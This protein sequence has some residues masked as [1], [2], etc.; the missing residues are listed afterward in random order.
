MKLFRKFLSLPLMRQLYVGVIAITIFSIAL[1]GCLVGLFFWNSFIIQV[2]DSQNLRIHTTSQDVDNWMNELMDNLRFYS[3]LFNN[4]NL[5]YGEQVLMGKALL[6]NNGAIHSITMFA[7]QNTTTFELYQFKTDEQRIPIDTEAYNLAKNR[8][9]EF[10]GKVF[11][12]DGQPM[13]AISLPAINESN[14]TVGVIRAIVNLRYMQHLFAVISHEKFGYSYILDETNRILANNFDDLLLKKQLK[15]PYDYFYIMTHNMFK[16]YKGIDGQF[17]IGSKNAIQTTQWYMVIEYPLSFI[18]SRLGFN[19]LLM[20]IAFLGS[21]IIGLLGAHLLYKN[22]SEPLIDLTAA[23]HKISRGDFEIS[24]KTEAPHELG[25]VAVAFNTMSSRLSGL[26]NDLEYSLESERLISDIAFTFIHSNGNT[27]RENIQQNLQKIGKTTKAN[28][29]WIFYTESG[30]TVFANRLQWYSSD[31]FASIPEHCRQIKMDDYPWLTYHLSHLLPFIINDSMLNDVICDHINKSEDAPQWSELKVSDSNEFQNCKAM[32]LKSQICMPLVDDSNVIGFMMLGF[33]SEK[34]FSESEKYL[35]LT[36]TNVIGTGIL[37]TR[38]SRL[39]SEEKERLAITL[40]SIGDA[41]IS[42]NTDGIVLTMNP[43]AEQLTGWNSAN[44]NGFILSEVLNIVCT[45]TSEPAINPVEEVIAKKN[46]CNYKTNLTLLNKNGIGY[47]IELSAAPIKTNDNIIVGTVLVFRDI[48]NKLKTE[49]EY[50]NIQKLEAVSYL[51]AGLAHDFNN[52]LFVVAGNIDL[53][54]DD[55]PED[56]KAAKL[57]NRAQESTMKGKDITNQLLTFAKQGVLITGTT[58]I[59][60]RIEHTIELFVSKS[61]ANVTYNI[62]RNLPLI[63]MADGIVHQIITNIVINAMQS[64]KD[65]YGQLTINAEL[66]HITE[67]ECLPLENGNY[68]SMHI[69]DNGEGIS[70]ENLPKLFIPYYTTKETGTGLG[71]PTVY[72]LLTRYNGYIRVTSKVGTGTDVE[73]FFPVVEPSDDN[74]DTGK[75]QESL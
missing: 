40:K 43:I 72:S 60:N 5:T 25:K 65:K 61:R 31:K 19:L 18:V 28:L 39:L 51:S 58:D 3:T 41:V 55:I 66:I 37:K 44:A 49:R 21:A 47:E 69:I 22:I 53:A 26:F 50:F 32:N 29:I 62:E 38:N 42:T 17:V 73:L 20:L 36:L 10:I 12:L 27:M 46:I 6:K 1:T 8:K 74:S 67:N 75:S 7:T 63:N 70:P 9:E 59:I 52:L 16:L 33:E 48:T 13:L 4:T 11:D 30:G 56:S 2:Q 64:I 35:L 45:D 34:E 14:E 23:A 68:I 54:M 24:L 15:I 71:L 57:L